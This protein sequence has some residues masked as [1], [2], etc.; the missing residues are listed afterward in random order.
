ML[1]FDLPK[2]KYIYFMRDKVRE[3][4]S[5]IKDF[6]KSFRFLLF[7]FS[8]ESFKLDKITV[9]P[10]EVVQ[11]VHIHLLILRTFKVNH[12]IFSILFK[13]R[14]FG[15]KTVQDVALCTTRF[16]ILKEA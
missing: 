11:V 12:S 8:M 10:L 1:T 13:M 14:V 3:Q 9:P 2:G 4:F 15:T 5:K 6:G 7:R 16:K